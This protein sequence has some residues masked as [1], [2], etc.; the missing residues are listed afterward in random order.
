MTFGL[1][2]LQ[3]QEALQKRPARGAGGWPSL[4][5]SGVLARQA[6]MEKILGGDPGGK[7][8]LR[9]PLSA[10]AR[11]GPRNR[12]SVH[13]GPPSAPL[14]VGLVPG[15]LGDRVCKPLPLRRRPVLE[16]PAPPAASQVMATGS[17]RF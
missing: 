1:R 13:T 10:S 14:L 3:A 5:C 16:R 6:L 12:G 11:G 15:L 17:S 8:T 2:E 9:P 7:V 4:T